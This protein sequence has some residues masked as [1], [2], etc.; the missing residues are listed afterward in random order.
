MQKTGIRN[1]EKRVPTQSVTIHPTAIIHPGAE[2]DEGVAVSPYS[3]IGENV[4]IGKGTKI[5]PHVVIEGVTTIDEDCVIYQFVSIG[6]PPQDMKFSGEM[7]EVIIGRRCV[8]REFVTINKGTFLGKGKTIL[9]SDNF[10]MAYAHIAH[11]CVIGDNVVMANSATL[12][13]HVEI[14]DHAIIGGLVPI[15]QFVKIGAYSMIGGGSTVTQDIPPFMTAVG[16]RARLYGLNSVGLKRHG[17]SPEDIKT[18]KMAYKII[19]RSGMTLKKALDK[20]RTDVEPSRHIDH[21]VDF[22]NASERGIIR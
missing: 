14:E 4:K 21:L 5:G 18:L 7:T 17:F 12:G 11:D 15:H 10:I 9:G 19:F 6:A 2:L 13:G 1:I 3:V 8:I 16:N 22:I 20:V